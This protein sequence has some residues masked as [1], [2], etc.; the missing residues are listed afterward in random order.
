MKKY[1]SILI[2]FVILSTLL[3][4]CY[5][6][7]GLETLAYVVAIGLD[8]GENNKIALTVQLAILNNTGGESVTNQF[9]NSTIT[10]VEC[11]SIDT[12]ISLIN[13]YMSK[14]VNLSHCKI[15]VF[16]EE[17]SYSGI[18]EYIATLINNIELRPDCNVIISRCNASD[19]LKNSKP[20]LESISSR[21]YEHI[22]NSS[23]YTGYSED[24]YIDTFGAKIRSHT[25]QAYA[26]LGGINDKNA[27]NASSGLSSYET[28]SNYKSNEIPVE[29]SVNLQNIGLAVFDGDKLIGELNGIETLSHLI[30]TNRLENATIS[31]PS[32]FNQNSTI[33][34]YLGLTKNTKNS[35]K[36]I[37]N[38]PYIKSKVYITANITSLD[39]NLNY[40]DEENLKLI[41]DYANTYLKQNILKYMYKTAK[42][43]K[44]DITDFGK[45]IVKNYLVWDDWIKSDWEN[46]YANSFFYLE[47]DTTVQSGFLFTKI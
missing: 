26:I 29:N 16:S 46:N 43:Y 37:N 40:S 8:K 24:V 32:P 42:N 23:E 21:Y 7:K 10:T 4:G 17:L 13:S 9:D 45:Y 25:S 19:F 39:E 30:L 12:G 11:N 28:D 2:I 38:T 15:T 1:I 3:T 34:L 18:S 31:I 14:K 35:V 22:F 44:S 6:A 41:E 5:D 27:N 47:V 36:L 20:K 33:E